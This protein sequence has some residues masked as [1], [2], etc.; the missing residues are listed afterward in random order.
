MFIAKNQEGLM[1]RVLSWW[2]LGHLIVFEDEKFM[3]GAK[4][5]F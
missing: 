1:G 2:S 4:K 5:G 3:K